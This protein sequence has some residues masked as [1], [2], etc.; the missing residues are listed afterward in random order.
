MTDDNAIFSKPQFDA[1]QP[2]DYDLEVSPDGN[3]A[4]LT[5]RLES[6]IMIGHAANEDEGFGTIQ[7]AQK[8]TINLAPDVPVVTDVKISQNIHS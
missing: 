8:L 6:P 2:P 3:T 7:F 4:V 1:N 5:M